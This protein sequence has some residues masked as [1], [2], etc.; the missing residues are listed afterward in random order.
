MKFVLLALVIAASAYGAANV[1][2]TTNTA[3]GVDFGAAPTCPDNTGATAATA[4]CVCGKNSQAVAIGEHCFVKA[5]GTG[6]MTAAAQK[7]CAADKS[8]GVAAADQTKC[9]CG[10]AAVV[11]AKD[12]FCDTSQYTEG[13]KLTKARCAGDKAN[14]VTKATTDCTCGTKTDKTA[15]TVAT[16]EQFCF[17]KTDKTGLI[18]A[19]T[20]QACAADKSTGVAAADQTKC[21]CGSAAVV[22]AKDE[23][24]DTSQYA[25]G[26]KLTKARCAGDKANGVTKATTD[27]TC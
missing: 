14:G 16:A 4:A 20:Q 3:A 21:Y 27:C 8:T 18:T 13:V 1:C 22:V 12:E 9:Y 7:A 6:V 15:G 2:T 25:E 11:V 17:I 23:F 24:C 5:D 19:A 10:S 26:V